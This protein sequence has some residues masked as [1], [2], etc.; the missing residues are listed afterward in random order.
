MVGPSLK[1]L[2]GRIGRVTRLLNLR[3]K[4]AGGKTS[5]VRW[6][7]ESPRGC[8]NDGKSIILKGAVNDAKFR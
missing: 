7:F 6:G 2:R 8:F 1:H 5:V 3:V 4:P